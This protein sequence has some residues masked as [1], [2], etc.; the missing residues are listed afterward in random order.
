MSDDE[1]YWYEA[2]DDAEYAAYLAERAAVAAVYDRGEQPQARPGDQE[3]IYLRTRAIE[4]LRSE[5]LQIR[6][7]TDPRCYGQLIL[8]YKLLPDGETEP[9]R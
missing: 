5:G 7:A 3:I 1:L 9:P 2:M 4:L 6:F 8:E